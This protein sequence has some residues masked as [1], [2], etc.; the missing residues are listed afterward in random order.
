MNATVRRVTLLC[1]KYTGC[2]WF[3]RRVTGK[4]LRILCY[5]GI[6]VADEH[7]FRG[8]LF[9]RLETFKARMIQLQK[10]GYPVISLDDALLGLKNERLPRGAVVLTFDD[11]WKRACTEALPWLT[12]QGWPV[13]LYV[14]SYHAEH[15]TQVAN[16]AIQY[17]FWA[18]SSARLEL[19]ELGEPLD[20]NLPESMEEAQ[21][22]VL[23]HCGALPDADTRQAFVLRLGEALEVDMAV[24]RDL[25]GFMLASCDELKAFADT[26]VDLQ[27]HTHRHILSEN[28]RSVLTRE[29]ADNCAFL[30]RLT[31]RQLQHFCYPSGVYEHDMWPELESLGVTS[32]TTC[33]P[34]FNYRDTPMLGL[35]RI[36]DEEGLT[37]LEFEAELSGILEFAKWIKRYLGKKASQHHQSHQAP[38]I[39]LAPVEIDRS[40]R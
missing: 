1:L 2:F 18:T 16:V 32:A 33:E 12:R 25:G 28:G 3:A 14:T 4:A 35:R 39:A 24:L 37:P 36:L 5:H 27:L 23:A 38:S 11:G 30:A 40:A 6:S 15:Q 7:E 22:V 10:L 17:L 21:K 20:L 9:M 26:G 29:L 34:G 8:R 13:T 19:R 31:K